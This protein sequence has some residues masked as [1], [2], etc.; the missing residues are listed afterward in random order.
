MLIGVVTCMIYCS[1]TVLTIRF[2]LQLKE[3]R[4][5]AQDRLTHLYQNPYYPPTDEDGD[6]TG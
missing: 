1:Y 2:F 5:A 6:T 4:Q 3:F